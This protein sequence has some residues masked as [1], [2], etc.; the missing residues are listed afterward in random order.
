[1][2]TIGDPGASRRVPNLC[3]FGEGLT[4]SVTGA[5]SALMVGA[6]CRELEVLPG[7]GLLGAVT[8]TEGPGGLTH[9]AGSFR[10]IRS[11]M[12][13][14]ADE[15]HAGAGSAYPTT[16]RAWIASTLPMGAADNLLSAAMNLP[17]FR[18]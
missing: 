17:C 2:Y 3:A 1:M 4:F 5:V 6:L 18:I 14:A 13:T 11:V 16:S 7:P 12:R 15:E 10:P 9:G 8:R